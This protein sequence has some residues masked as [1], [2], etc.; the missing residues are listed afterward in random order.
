V[1]KEERKIYAAAWYL[2]NR[3]KVLASSKLW[4]QTNAI[5]ENLRNRAWREDNPEKEK[6]RLTRYRKT[7]PE[8]FAEKA[9]ERRARHLKATPSWV[10]E[11][12]KFLIK[13]CYFLAK[14]RT[15]VT[16]IKWVVD[17]I[18]PL[19][20]E[21]VS[22]LHTISNLQVITEVENCRKNNRYDINC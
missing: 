14:L 18:I 17:H 16:G 2:R 7:H 15:K 22:G 20:G 10:D 9:G 13:E 4:Q 8:Y 5:S 3:E 6:A 21:L 11:N 19:K 1:T 12:E